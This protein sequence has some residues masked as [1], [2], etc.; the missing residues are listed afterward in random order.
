MHTYA[1]VMM[2]MYTT[3]MMMMSA[4]MRQDIQGKWEKAIWYDIPN[5]HLV[6]YKEKMA[7]IEHHQNKQHWWP[8]LQHLSL[9]CRLEKW[10]QQL[11]ENP[12]IYCL[13]QK[14][15]P[16]TCLHFQQTMSIEAWPPLHLHVRNQAP[17]GLA[18]TITGSISRGSNSTFNDD[19]SG[20]TI[21]WFVSQQGKKSTLHMRDED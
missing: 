1:T 5:V 18:S 3:V 17:T 7:F 12:T 16:L 4:V 9:F 6:D 19:V 21:K 20:K 2:M 14:K 8:F 13:W 11:R 10:K 15:E